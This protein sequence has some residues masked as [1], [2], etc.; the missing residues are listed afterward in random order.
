MK[1]NMGKIDRAVRAFLIAPTA[2]I[3]AFAI[4]AGSV[5]ASTP[6]G[7]GSGRELPRLRLARPARRDGDRGQATIELPGRLRRFVPANLNLSG[8]P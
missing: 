8:R 6:A 7:G 2:V 3:A 4:G 1:R 5:G